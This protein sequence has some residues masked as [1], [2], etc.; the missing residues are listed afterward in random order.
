MIDIKNFTETD[1]EFQEIV[2]IYNLVSHDN[3]THID[4]EKDNW[5]L[6]DKS[7]KCD[8]LLLYD[9]N[10]VIGFLRYLQG[11]ELNKQKCYFNIFIDPEYNGNG[12]RQ[13][14]FDKML[15]DVKLFNCNGLYMEIFD[16]PNY[17]ESKDFLEKHLFINKFKI[18]EYSL[19]LSTLD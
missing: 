15:E 16:H 13:L 8:R 6:L 11:R 17:T 5:A 2:R 9:D 7:R 3:V 4:E 14:L 12:Y 10:A 19:D 1:F 18:K